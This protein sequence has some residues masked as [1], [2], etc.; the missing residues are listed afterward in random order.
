MA[1]RI[2]RMLSLRNG[3]TDQPASPTSPTTAG[4]APAKDPN[5]NGAS[6]TASK[7][8]PSFDELPKFHDFNG[9]AWDVWGKD[10]ELGTI[11][12]LTP[13]VVQT[14]AREEIRYVASR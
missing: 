2:K 3:K 12:M 7:A 9:C 4:D 5:T 8:L 1:S 6:A 11:N 10:D 13:D 14:A